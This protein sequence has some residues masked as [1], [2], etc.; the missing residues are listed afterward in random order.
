MLYVSAPYIREPPRSSQ[1]KLQS[2]FD[3]E[4][5][6]VLEK[7]KGLHNVDKTA[8]PSEFEGE[9]NQSKKEQGVTNDA[10]SGFKKRVSTWDLLRDHNVL[11]HE[12]G[13]DEEEGGMREE[14]AEGR[15]ERELGRG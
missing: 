13:R 8:S 12:E 1:M 11:K 9:S 2:S 15:Q 4:G 3:V 14:G 6:K 10:D 5:C 7:D